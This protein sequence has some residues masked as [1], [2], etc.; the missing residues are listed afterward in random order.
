MSSFLRNFRDGGDPSPPPSPPRETVI[1]TSSWYSRGG[2]L[3]RGVTPAEGEGEG[4]PADAG[5][6]AG[7]EGFRSAGGKGGVTRKCSSVRLL[8]ETKDVKLTRTMLKSLQQDFAVQ[9]R[10]FFILSDCFF[11][12]R[13]LGVFGLKR[14]N[15]CMYI[16]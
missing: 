3:R 12:A 7:A 5:A 15:V 6:G 16:L 13:V 11:M 14:W 4:D 8:R 10:F 1:A 2:L 9:V